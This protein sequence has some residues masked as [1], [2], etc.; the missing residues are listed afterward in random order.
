MATSDAGSSELKAPKS[1]AQLWHELK[2][3]CKER[4]PC[5]HPIKHWHSTAIARAFTLIYTTSLLTLLTRIQ[6]NLLG[7]R[8]YLSS[9]VLQAAH[10]PQEHTISLENRDDDNIDR[11]Y[12][13]DFETNRR[14]LTFSWWLLHQG[15]RQ[16]RTDVEGA[17]KDIFGQSKPTEEVSLEKLSASVLDVREKVEG[18]TPDERK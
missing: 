1:K 6:L 11:S 7:R 17:V 12:G 16:I 15:W 5:T 9:V 4:I 14:Y 18:S 2:I 13:S 10:N 8:S 3:S